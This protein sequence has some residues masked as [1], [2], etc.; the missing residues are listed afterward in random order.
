[1]GVCLKCHEKWSRGHRCPPGSIRSNLRN[2]LKDG[3]SAVHLVSLLAEA[4]ED[5]NDSSKDDIVHDT[6]YGQDCTDALEEF[7]SYHNTHEMQSDSGD[8]ESVDKAIVTQHISNAINPGPP[9]NS[10]EHFPTGDEDH[11]LNLA[12]QE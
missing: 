10:E 3:E 5:E 12:A 7:D 6:R 1:M 11:S 8:D 9:D 4:L 2:R